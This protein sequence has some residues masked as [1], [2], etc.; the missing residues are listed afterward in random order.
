MQDEQLR[1]RIELKRKACIFS[2]Q[3]ILNQVNLIVHIGL[4]KWTRDTY[5]R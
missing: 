2:S 3:K 4:V 5:L 1:K